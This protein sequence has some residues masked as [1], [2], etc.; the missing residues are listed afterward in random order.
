MELEKKEFKNL[1]DFGTQPGTSAMNLGTLPRGRKAG[2]Q[3]VK[4][5]K[6]DPESA[7]QEALAAFPDELKDS[8]FLA[9]Y[10]K[11]RNIARLKRESAKAEREA[12]IRI[13][14]ASKEAK[15]ESELV[16]AFR[17]KDFIIQIFQKP[18]GGYYR[19]ILAR[20]KLSIS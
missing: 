15:S 13:I 12:G 3:K 17:S 6:A 1:L 19:E 11:H 18:T 4:T 20:P 9:Q 7:Y 16:G 2:S 5:S 8:N 10:V 14:K